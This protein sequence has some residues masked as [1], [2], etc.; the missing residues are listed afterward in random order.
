M[1]TPNDNEAIA[2]PEFYQVQAL[3]AN[4]ILLA[5]KANWSGLG[6]QQKHTLRPKRASERRRC[7]YQRF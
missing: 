6:A 2:L 1:P 5:G 7:Y 3:P 4:F